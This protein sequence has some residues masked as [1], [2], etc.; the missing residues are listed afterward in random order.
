MKKLLRN[1][2]IVLAFFF[3]I[4]SQGLNAQE[5]AQL[6]YNPNAPAGTANPFDGW[7][8]VQIPIANDAMETTPDASDVSGFFQGFWDETNLYFYFKVVDDTLI[9]IDP[10]ASW[11]GDAIELAISLNDESYNLFWGGDS[12][13]D[14]K[15]IITYT[16][17]AASAGA[18]V[19]EMADFV[20]SG[21]A[22]DVR[23]TDSTYEI[24]IK[25]PI[26]SIGD[27]VT[28]L[29]VLEYIRAEI[30]INDRDDAGSA[31][32]KNMLTWS[33]TTNTNNDVSGF[34]YLYLGKFADGDVWG[35]RMNYTEYNSDNWA[36]FPIGENMVYGITHSTINPL[37]NSGDPWF[38]PDGSGEDYGN[39][40][41][42]GLGE[43]AYVEDESYTDFRMTVKM[44]R[45]DFEGAN[46]YYD[47]GILWGLTDNM[48]FKYVN[49]GTGEK[50]NNGASFVDGEG[51]RGGPLGINKVA[52][53][54]IEMF[55]DTLFHEV[56]LEKVGN[57]VVV[58]YEGLPFFS[59][60][61]DA[62]DTTGS[63]GFG[64]WN[65]AVYVDDVVI[66]VI[67]ELT[68][69]T[70]T[71]FTTS[72]G[73]LGND[74]I[75]GIPEATTVQAVLDGLTLADGASAIIVQK[76]ED[77]YA[78]EVDGAEVVSIDM[79]LIVTSESGLMVNIGLKLYVISDD[80]SIA[81]YFA[82]L[83]YDEETG[84]ISTIE[85]TILELF[86]N[87]IRPLSTSTEAIIDADGN[88][89]TDGET[90]IVDGMFYRVTAE[91]GTTIKDYRIITYAP[92]YP[93]LSS[94]EVDSE[95]HPIIIDAFF[96]DWAA[97]DNVTSLDSVID[98]GENL[99]PPSSPE[100]LSASMKM[101]WDNDFLYVYIRIVDDIIV[102]SETDSWE[103]DG[104][105]IALVMT[106]DIGK[107]AG[108]NMFWQA[109]TQPGNM[110]LTYV[111]GYTMT[112]F[113]DGLNTGS[114]M[115][116]FSGSILEKWEIEDGAHGY[117][118]EFQLPWSTLNG[119]SNDNPFVVAKGN[120]FSMNMAVNDNDGAGR[121]HAI[122]ILPSNTNRDA[123]DFPLVK[124]EDFD[125]PTAIIDYTE[126]DL[127][128]YPN[129]VSDFLHFNVN[130]DVKSI[131]ILSITGQVI[132]IM[133]ENF[134]G[135]MSL[136][137]SGLKSGIYLVKV[138]LESGKP[139]VGKFNKR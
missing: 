128:I 61:D 52:N 22:I 1:Y 114:E 68:G 3:G 70:D 15:I 51:L 12:N 48:N 33:G 100:D 81:A 96:D 73:T 105:E 129:P 108:Y 62:I 131:E 47:L 41:G 137:V 2:F 106:D 122:F 79:T 39:G 31:A 72:V 32:R 124:L 87:K 27:A 30:V 53:H 84:I 71:S 101:A 35:H 92:P 37:H 95:S 133:K 99:F 7:G 67:T 20:S 138:N 119:I 14:G 38:D 118:V 109:N 11:N 82:P 127:K 42:S 16:D 83:Q 50:N 4:I 98:N 135:E 43:F 58:K 60:I 121:E 8:D 28:D 139:F 126:Q 136:N 45:P 34:G 94:R 10:A 29:S 93:T 130:G 91:D 69:S 90:N 104:F 44:A 18:R 21:G 75:I 117:E 111:H 134:R 115:R 116:D 23:T 86:L 78:L 88:E 113:A 97:Y 59:I 25:V 55:G 74:T 80:T 46:G 66:E 103:N 65:D 120:Q 54:N 123:S 112:Q 19:L 24:A 56:I 125:G 9:D 77:G 63:V 89:V 13:D 17:S 5:S 57:M 64:S 40:S 107:R 26:A 110:K 49:F 102:A 76:N 132:Q 6:V 36:T 85:G